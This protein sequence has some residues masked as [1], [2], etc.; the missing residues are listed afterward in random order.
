M[1][2]EPQWVAAVITA[3][4]ATIDSLSELVHE[5][6]SSGA[7][8]RDIDHGLSEMTAYFDATRARSIESDLEAG[9][10]R[11]ADAFP[12]LPAPTMKWEATRTEDW[13]VMWK[14]RFTPTP[15]GERLLVTPPWRRPDAGDRLIVIIEPAAAFG[16][17]THETTR[18]CLALLEAVADDLG[19]RVGR[20]SML[21]VGCGSG[22]LALAAKRLGFSPV[23]G[24]DNDP[25]AIE[26]ARRNA[27]LNDLAD[28][29]QW[30]CASLE[31]ISVSWDLVAANLDP[32]TLEAHCRPLIRAARYGLIVSGVPSDQWRRVGALFAETGLI[33]QTEIVDGEWAAGLFRARG[34]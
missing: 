5:L 20:S 3:P 9:L 6:G 4:I 27:Q 8:I 7:V 23:M 14:D 15:V 11:A 17:G 34:V 25:I 10:S 26:S 16:T 28:V 19:E 12:D 24:I 1:S 2:D 30:A 13:A 22:I 21:D 31:S 32:L 18:S 33:L 29:T